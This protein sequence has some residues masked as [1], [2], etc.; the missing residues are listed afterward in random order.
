MNTETLTLELARALLFFTVATPALAILVLAIASAL[1]RHLPEHR[2]QQLAAVAFSSGLFAALTLDI[3]LLTGLVKKGSFGFG[4]IFAWRSYEFGLD[5]ILDPLSATLLSLDFLL[6]GIVGAFSARYLHNERHFTAF[7][8][9]LL[10]ACLGVAIVATAGRLDLLLAGWELIGLSSA[11]LVAF[12]MDRQA[13]VENSMRVF[14]IYRI[15][16]AALLVA[17]VLAHHA[18]IFDIRDSQEN[19]HSTFIALTLCIAAAGKGAIFPFTP[20]LPRAMDGPTPSS[21]IFYG[22]LSIHAS[23]FLLLRTW[24]LISQ[25]LSVQILIAALGLLTAIYATLTARARSDI[26]S[27]LSLSAAAQ[28]GLIWIEIA[29]GLESLAL[30][31]ILAHAL[32]RSWQ[33]LSAPSAL[34][35]PPGLGLQLFALPKNRVLHAAAIEGFALDR[36]LFETIPSLP[37]R[38]LLAFDRI[39]RAIATRAERPNSPPPPQP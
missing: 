4:L 18:Q 38:A 8:V 28:V 29:L 25:A 36:I 33:L 20:W 7:Y 5:L 3:A 27:I 13:P 24:P 11:L 12:F 30:L 34:Q 19:H 16:D 1:Q 22:A 32:Y 37:R 26:K 15:S 10:L 31:H 14:S 39:D 6:C 17:V 9:L 2:M 21:A 23:P 35:S